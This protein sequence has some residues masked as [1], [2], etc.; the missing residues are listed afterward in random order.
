VV[1]TISAVELLYYSAGQHLL[2][3]ILFSICDVG[4]ERWEIVMRLCIL[5][6]PAPGHG[7]GHA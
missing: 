6:Q 7:E 1:R 2:K 3:C 4:F 5:R